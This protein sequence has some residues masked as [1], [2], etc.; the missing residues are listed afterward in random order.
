MQRGFLLRDDVRQGIM[1]TARFGSHFLTYFRC[2]DEERV[3]SL[4]RYDD[5][6]AARQGHRRWMNKDWHRKSLRE[7]LIEDD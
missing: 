6:E 2:R 4:A 1:E 3:I 7:L 5:E